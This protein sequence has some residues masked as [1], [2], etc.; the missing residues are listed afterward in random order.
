MTDRNAALLGPDTSDTLETSDAVLTDTAPTLEGYLANLDTERIRY[1]LEHRPQAD[2]SVHTRVHVNRD[3]ERRAHRRWLNW[4]TRSL[5]MLSLSP[6]AR[7]R[8]SPRARA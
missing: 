7:V 6:L 8:R 3:D 4:S 5:R 1:T 2:G